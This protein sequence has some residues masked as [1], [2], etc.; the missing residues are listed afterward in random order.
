MHPMIAA[1]L[2]DDGQRY[3]S[4]RRKLVEVLVDAVDDTVVYLWNT[5]TVDGIEH[6]WLANAGMVVETDLT[7]DAP[8]VRVACS[9]GHGDPTFDDLVVRIALLPT[10]PPPPVDAPAAP[11]VTAAVTAG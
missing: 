2:D 3:T 11:G 10:P 7:G 1:R 5:W 6:A 9:D 4:G 8:A